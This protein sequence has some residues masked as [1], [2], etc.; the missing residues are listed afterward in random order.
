MRCFYLIPS[1]HT[2]Q[3]PYVYSFKYFTVIKIIR[4]SYLKT[5]I[6]DHSKDA[7]VSH[8][9]QI[10]LV[11]DKE[12]WSFSNY[13]QTIKY[14]F[15]DGQVLDWYSIWNQAWF[16]QMFLSTHVWESE[17]LERPNLLSAKMELLVVQCHTCLL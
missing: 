12:I 3:W 11:T 17:V 7:L 16:P 1:S 5:K 2:I 15:T 10:T 13:Q 4:F 9:T 8:D 14:S 6:C